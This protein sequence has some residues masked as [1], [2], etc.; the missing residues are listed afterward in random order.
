MGTKDAIRENLA[1][2]MKE[3]GTKNVELARAVNV[4]KAAVTN[5]LNGSNSID[6]DLVPRI[7]AFFGVTVDEFLSVGK[8]ASSL[9]AEE[10][11]LIDC[12]RRMKPRFRRD[13]M[14]LAESM[15]DGGDAKNLADGESR[16]VG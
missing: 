13:L 3:S 10:Q 14:T 9:S 6:M 4:S 7:C 16:E 12:Y 11:R 8:S 2:L 15:A 5:W 1:R